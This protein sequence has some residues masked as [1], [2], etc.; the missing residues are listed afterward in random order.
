MRKN[1]IIT[2]LP[3]CGKSTLLRDVIAKFENKVGFVTNEVREGEERVGFEIETCN[4]K[5]AR[6]AAVNFDSAI[7]VSKYGVDVASLETIIP[8]VERFSSGDILYLDEVGQMELYS[9]KF[10]E[11]TQKYLDSPNACL[12]TVSM[13]FEHE[14]INAVK[15]RKDIIWV[16]I[17]PGR[18]EDK[19]NFVEKL[20]GK[21]E[22]AKRYSSEPG[23]F[24]R[25]GNSLEI[26]TDHGVRTVTI[27]DKLHCNCVFY[28]EHEICSHVLA[29]EEYLKI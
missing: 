21:I 4:N 16:E 29:A 2:G 25:V 11:L 26:Q 27:S 10:Q 19:K 9:G 14:F 23:R 6:L 18:W 20:V 28:A 7:R 1:I 13:V 12:M 17:T 22:K 8:E 5:K 24:T 3:K 15:A